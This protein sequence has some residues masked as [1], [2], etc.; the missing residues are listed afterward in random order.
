MATL[1]TSVKTLT[2]WA[3]EIDPKGK[4]AMIAELLSQTNEILGDMMFKEGNLPTGERISQRTGLPTVYWRLINKGVPTSKATS[5]Q[6]DEQCGNLQARS[7]VDEDMASLEGNLNTFRLNESMA[8]LEAMNQEMASTLFYGSPVNPEEFVGLANRYNDTTA[9]NGQN[10]LNAGGSGAD[11]SSVWLCG[12]GDRS[13]YGIFPKGSNAGLTHEDLGLDDVDDSDGNPY[14]A[15]KDL[16]KWKNGIALKDWRYVVRIANIDVSDLA[17]LSGTQEL[18]DSTL[19]IKLMSRAVDR[20]P[21]L[22]GVK[23]V[24]YANRTVLSLLR[25]VGL[26]KSSSAVTVQEGLNQFGQT[27][28]ETRFL[29]IPVRLVDALT[30][31][32]AVVS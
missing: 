4:P 17:G 19:L 18:T 23:P 31:A 32:E 13:V 10:I 22:N 7:H 26:E 3:K 1:G 29:G 5:A 27:I 15:Y 12:W 20:L 2:D 25:V 21:T 16:F 28:F 11:N 6:V 8:F 30:E 9:A 14:R 24:F